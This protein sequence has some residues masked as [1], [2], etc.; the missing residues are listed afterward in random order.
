M[1][2]KML[3]GTAA[4]SL[5]LGAIFAIYGLSSG[6]P[7]S[8]AGVPSPIVL[9]PTGDVT[10]A[11]AGG[12][13]LRGAEM[14]SGTNFR[15]AV[16]QLSAALRAM[17]A[18]A[19][20]G[21]PVEAVEKGEWQRIVAAMHTPG[22]EAVREVRA[23]IDR[24]PASP[25][26]SQALMA[27]GDILYDRGLW[28]EA[29]KAFDEVEEF[30][31]NPSDA[32]ALRY[33]TG[34]CL[35]QLEEYD[36]ARDLYTS[37][38]DTRY[39]ADAARFY[40]GYIAY[41]NKD[42]SRAAD[43]M[44]GLAASDEMPT[45]M[46]NYYLAQM[47]LLAKDY[48]EALTLAEELARN[49]DVPREFL[50]EAL[51]VAGE[52]AHQLGD[53]KTCVE[54]LRRYIETTSSP[55]PSA[56]YL[57]GVEDYR[58][59]NYAEAIE[60]LTPV[61]EE[62]SSIGQ[63]AYLFIGQSYLQ[64]KNYTAAS[65][66]LEKASK[67]SFDPEVEEAAL[68]NLGVAQ[69]QGGKV[70]FGSSV[71]LFEEFMQ[72]FPDSELAPK[73]MDYLLN[74]YMTDN[75]YPAALAAIGRVKHPSG[76]VLAAK[77]KVLYLLGM[78]ELQAKQV[79][80]AISHLEQA[81]EMDEYSSEVATEATLWLAEAEY[82]AGEYADAV[83]DLTYYLRQK[84]APNHAIA[85]YDL[86]YARFAQKQF[87]DAK[88]AFK[89]FVANPADVSPEL[90]ADALNRMA[91]SQYYTSDFTGAAAT[92]RRAYEADPSAGDYP[93]FQLGLMKG[94]QRNHNEKIETLTDM[95]SRF[96]TSA[97][98]PTALLEMGES[99]TQ[100]SNSGRAIE[101]YTTLV[102][103][104]P[105]TAQGRQGHLLLAI[106]Y[107]HSG[108]RERAIEHYK[109]VIANY[110][111]SEEARVASDD[112]KQLYA[113]DGRIHEYMEFINDVPD[114]PKPETAELAELTL[115][116]ARSALE[117]G[118]QT[119][120]L[121][122]AKEVTERYPDSPQATEALEIVAQAEFNAGNPE[123]ALEAYRAL[124][125]RSISAADV[126][127]ARLGIMR[128][129]REMADNAAA[130]E[131][132]DKLLASSSLGA[133]DK[134]EV[135]FTKALALAD[136]GR[137]SEAVAIWENLSK[138]MDSLYGT[139][140]AY[141]LGQYYYDHKETKK[142]LTVANKIIDANPPHDYWLARGFILLS[143][144][145]RRQGET[146]EADEYLRSLKENYPGSEGDIFR[147]IDER[148]K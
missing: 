71:G 125:A 18:E 42:Y 43:L 114:A 95:M 110:P 98:I 107:L 27:V 46:T 106:T 81:S 117:H 92:Y 69:M 115:Q 100:L 53:S 89:R 130:L 127:A 113:D 129:C 50:G 61:T 103:R 97:L 2:H 41:V 75:N 36:R 105:N 108:N 23:W 32:E 84:D 8:L 96:P 55:L 67:M 85:Y 31:L 122:H 141:Y 44:R 142:A 51:R 39:Y 147:M 47:A 93:M 76:D 99:Y 49:A 26:R 140:S 10:S 124:E 20:P 17:A 119:D 120:A 24:Y 13:A 102:N 37:L 6:A 135:I 15:G 94:L 64:Q 63:S 86:G 144:I 48:R 45:E 60:R 28:A 138:D 9:L 65:L 74:G 128:V 12:Y 112:L 145:L 148:L 91:D 111:S 132:A 21:A 66:A 73:V 118:R 34:Y 143:D 72:R 58:M 4:R 7:A 83:S 101:T 109:R 68:Y 59:G 56:L 90:R 136:L 88:D 54:Y 29:V 79:K 116:S 1:K 52:A 134:N 16:D 25:R 38:M 123:A 77:Q 131:A 40:L 126:N 137:A 78:K 80:S 22:A 3:I 5:A 33:R 82:A 139:K 14:L 104:Y 70:P 19:T 57:L 87:A 133:S 62:Q 30:T 35:L 146:F 11:G 121:R